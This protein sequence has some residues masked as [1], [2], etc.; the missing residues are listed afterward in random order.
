MH[1]VKLIIENW[2][3]IVSKTKCWKNFSIATPKPC[4]Y[5]ELAMGQIK[6]DSLLVKQPMKIE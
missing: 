6:S 4:D 3:I 1:F 2:V 5:Q